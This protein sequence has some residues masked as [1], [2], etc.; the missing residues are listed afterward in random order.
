MKHK[1]TVIF[2][3]EKDMMLTA[4]DV[5]E[6]FHATANGYVAEGTLPSKEEIVKAIKTDSENGEYKTSL[7]TIL[8]VVSLVTAKEATAEAAQQF[9]RML[10]SQAQKLAGAAVELKSETVH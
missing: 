2:D 9:L 6:L 10:E 7:A 1:L 3:D 8:A 4:L 5:E